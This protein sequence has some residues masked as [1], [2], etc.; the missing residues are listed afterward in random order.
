MSRLSSSSTCHVGGRLSGSQEE[1]EP[2]GREFGIPTPTN[3][4]HETLPAILGLVDVED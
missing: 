2:S 1:R 4:K 3:L